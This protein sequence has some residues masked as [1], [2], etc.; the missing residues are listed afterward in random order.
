MATSQCAIEERQ[1]EI[2]CLSLS[3]PNGQAL[4]EAPREQIEDFLIGTYG[5]ARRTESG[6]IDI[7]G[8]I[9]RLLSDG[10]PATL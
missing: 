9:D 4:M 7:D 3:S 2:F 10:G 6:M 1:R 5:R 8:L